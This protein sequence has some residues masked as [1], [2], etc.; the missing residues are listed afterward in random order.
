MGKKLYPSVQ[1]FKEFVK[2]HPHLIKEVRDGKTTWQDLY[3]EWYLLGEEDSRWNSDKSE[4]GTE[5]ETKK[6]SSSDFL[7]QIW[8]NVK[9]MDPNQIQ[10][11]LSSLSEA[12]GAV[13]GILSQFQA[14]GRNKSNQNQSQPANP[15]SFRKD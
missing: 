9:N 14:N 15:F 3:E 5:Q 6:N 12:I 4:D 8:N 7:M 2:K 11:H 10:H 13:Q 1:E